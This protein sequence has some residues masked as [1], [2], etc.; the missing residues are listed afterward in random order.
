MSGLLRRADQAC[1][2][3][4]ILPFERL[5][6]VELIDYIFHKNTW[7]IPLI[8]VDQVYNR[9]IM[10]LPHQIDCKNIRGVYQ[11]LPQV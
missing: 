10:I 3:V 1:T 2:D 4:V 11:R 7:R 6:G 8:C 5:K 9:E